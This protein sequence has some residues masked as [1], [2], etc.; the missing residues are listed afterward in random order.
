MLK[1]GGLD[2]RRHNV[3]GRG[4]DVDVNGGSVGSEIDVAGAAV[5]DGGVGEAGASGQT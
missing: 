2:R 4:V 5:D 1:I 3:R